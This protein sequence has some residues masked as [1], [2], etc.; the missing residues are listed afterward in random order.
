VLL[1]LGYTQLYAIVETVVFTK[2]LL[3]WQGFYHQPRGRHAV[4]ASDL[5]EP[6]RHFVERHALSMVLR[7]EL[8]VSDFTMTSAGACLMSDTAR[9]KYMTLL[10][11]QWEV[12]STAL[13]QTEPLT[14]LEHV[15]K[16]A[17]A[18]KDFITKGETFHAFRLR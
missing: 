18:L 15:Q 13:G 16:Q 8:A 14:W 1:S 7:G 4:L 6:F 2:G 9:R 5:M 11:Q 12:K 17:Q 10:L 3:P